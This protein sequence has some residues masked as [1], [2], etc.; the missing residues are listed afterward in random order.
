MSS[1]GERHLLVQIHDA[2]EGSGIS[3]M[4]G[5]AWSGIMKTTGS[6]NYLIITI[7]TESQVG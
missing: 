7:N 1:A 6:H 3:E 4:V 2:K 5:P